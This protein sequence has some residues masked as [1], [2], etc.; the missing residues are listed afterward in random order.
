MA[1]VGRLLLGGC[2]FL[3]EFLQSSPAHGGGLAAADDSDILAY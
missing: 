2:P 1:A 3:P